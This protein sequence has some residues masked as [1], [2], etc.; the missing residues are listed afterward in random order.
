MSRDDDIE[1]MVYRMEQDAI[2]NSSN[3]AWRYVGQ[4]YIDL[5]ARHNFP[6]KAGNNTNISSPG[7]FYPVTKGNNVSI[8]PGPGGMGIEVQLEDGYTGEIGDYRIESNGLNAVEIT[9]YHGPSRK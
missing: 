9:R 1:D 2:A 4:R 5:H 7:P 3:N 8:Q 6:V